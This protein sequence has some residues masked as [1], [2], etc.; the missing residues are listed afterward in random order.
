MRDLL[1]APDDFARRTVEREGVPGR[2]WL[3]ALP[4]LVSRLIR[5]WGLAIR[6]RLMAGTTA[7]SG[8]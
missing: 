4:E 3:D 6:A 1:V 5:G 8:R 2:V 7:S